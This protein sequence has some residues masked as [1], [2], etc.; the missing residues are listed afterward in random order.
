MNSKITACFSI[1][2][3]AFFLSGCS[4][5]LN[6]QLSA[7]DRKSLKRIG[8]VVAEISPSLH[9]PRVEVIES[10]QG[11]TVKE[12]CFGFNRQW[13]IDDYKT[14]QNQT[15]NYVKSYLFEEYPG[16]KFSEKAIPELLSK[17]SKSNDPI[18][19]VIL[20]EEASASKEW[21]A[22]L[23]S[24]S[25]TYADI[26]KRMTPLIEKAEVDALM[27]ITVYHNAGV[28]C[29][30]R[31]TYVGMVGVIIVPTGEKVYERRLFSKHWS[32]FDKE[33]NIAR[34]EK[35]VKE[36]TQLFYSEIMGH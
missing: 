19:I 18:K 15:L 36:T 10:Y 8:L 35:F 25:I 32:V 33:L 2:C 22:Y 7:K 9:A 17:L 24:D 4:N 23:N 6:H 27:T 34:F 28:L 26:I 29:G 16:A 12:L 11:T 31:S 14:A 20:G 21:A 5:T 3:F 30:K 13:K 1:I